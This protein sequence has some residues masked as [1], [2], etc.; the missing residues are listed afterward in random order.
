MN[1]HPEQSTLYLET[2]ATPARQ[3]IKYFALNRGVHSY[4][5]IPQRD[6]CDEMK[7]IGYKFVESY[8]LDFETIDYNTDTLRAIPIDE[9]AWYKAAIFYDYSASRAHY[10]G[11]SWHHP[12]DGKL[13]T[14]D[15]IQ[16]G[17]LPIYYGG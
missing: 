17:V 3:A 7:V 4:V 1:L 10:C 9:R 13:L 8:T 16:S 11:A 12:V 14:H 2:E 15:E 5:M 6:E